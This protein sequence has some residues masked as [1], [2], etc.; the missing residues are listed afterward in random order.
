MAPPRP[1]ALRVAEEAVAD[2]LRRDL[3]CPLMTRHVNLLIQASN[4]KARRARKPRS[5]HCSSHTGAPC[6]CF[7]FLIHALLI[8]DVAIF[9]TAAPLDQARRCADGCVAGSQCH[10]RRSACHTCCCSIT[11]ASCAA[12]RTAAAERAIASSGCRAAGRCGCHKQCFCCACGCCA[13]THSASD[14]AADVQSV[15]ALI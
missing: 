4:R 7:R 13:V 8:C 6:R 14:R 12:R 11:A 3:Q 15:R 1:P 5:A 2:P 9:W 10:K